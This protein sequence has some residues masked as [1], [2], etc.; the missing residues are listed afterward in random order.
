LRRGM[1]GAAINDDEG[2]DDDEDD[3]DDILSP[4]EDWADRK[5]ERLDPRKEK[6]VVGRG[7]DVAVA[8]TNRANRASFIGR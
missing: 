7:V 1:V 6:A 3:D 4:V 5:R 2:E 8:V